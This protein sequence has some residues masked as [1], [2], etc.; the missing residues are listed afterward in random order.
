MPFEPP[1]RR[2]SRVVSIGPVKI[3]GGHPVSVQSMTNTVTADTAATLRQINALAQAGCQIARV[4]VP[5]EQ[6]VQSLPVLLAESP[7]PIVADIHFDYKLALGAIKSGVHG[8]RLNPGNIGSSARVREV[9]RAA[10]DAGIP[11]RIGVNG[12]SLEK[13][14][15]QKYGGV[16]PEALTESALGQ[17]ELLEKAG[18]SDIKI[19]LK[20][21]DVPRTVAA[22]QMLAK[23]CD[24]PMHIGLT[25]AGPPGRGGL[26]S[27]V[28]LGILFYQGIGDTMRVSLTGDPIEEVR[29]A[30]EILNAL[31]ISPLPFDLISCPTCGR[32]GIDVAA[33]IAQV[34]SALSGLVPKKPLKIAVMGCAVNG[35]GEA[36]EAD[37]GIAGGRGE[38][39]LFAKGE[40]IGKYREE[41]L[42]GKL[43]EAVR[44][45]M[46]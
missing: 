33:L 7:L 22:Y 15:L 27:A 29:A 34:E 36:R 40:I 30:K 20:T 10:K 18:F 37:F 23:L 17:A 13:A 9:A 25:E 21:S 43:A 6:T 19:S 1:P 44:R 4:A 3:G 8:L 45:G 41:E 24:Y 39:L 46:G 26:R 12:G 38:G 31:H 42:V 16:T 14:L 5:D 35:P 11:I 2:K 28:A 32:S